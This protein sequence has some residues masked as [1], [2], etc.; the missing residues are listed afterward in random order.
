M[1]AVNSTARTKRS[2]PARTAEPAWEIAYLFPPQG[3]WSEEDYLALEDHYGSHIR[4]ELSDGRLEVLPMPTEPHQLIIAFLWRSLDAFINLH[5]PGVTLFSGIRV[6]LRIG[7]AVKFREP[8]IVYMKAEHSARRHNEF[9][10]GADLVMEVVSGDAK[11][12]NRDWLTKPKEYAAAGIPEYWIID[13]YRKLIRVLVLRGKAYRRH[14]DFKLGS[15][16]TS[17]LLPGFSVAVSDV[18]A[19]AAV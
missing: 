11:D 8:D 12:R 14:G 5:A 4:V 2:R 18:F 16:A 17:V 10:E 9:W 1:V 7:K 15:R 13:P 6:K 3:S 19:A